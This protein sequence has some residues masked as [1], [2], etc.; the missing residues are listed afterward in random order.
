MA[1]RIRFRDGVTRRSHYAFT[2]FD[3]NGVS[4]KKW[5]G[6]HVPLLRRFFCLNLHRQMFEVVDA[7]WKPTPP[8]VVAPES[9]SVPTAG[10]EDANPLPA[11]SLPAF[12]SPDEIAAEAKEDA[13]KDERPR[14]RGK[15]S[16]VRPK[17]ANVHPQ[18]HGHLGARDGGSH[19][20]R[21]A[22]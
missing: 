22:K 7:D 21:G 13:D 12:L 18:G 2:S 1:V 8:A 3:E 5:L 16:K 15:Y 14:R 4:K 9:E 17:P 10:G 20:A 19:Q 11:E 6:A